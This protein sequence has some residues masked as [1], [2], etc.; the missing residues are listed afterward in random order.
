MQAAQSTVLIF[1]ASVF[2]FFFTSLLPPEAF[3][4]SSTGRVRTEEA[5]TATPQAQTKQGFRLQ[6]TEDEKRWLQGH[7]SV[8]ISGPRAFPPFYFFDKNGDVHGIA[9]DY[10]SLIL[11]YLQLTPDIQANLFWP[12]VL[13]KAKAREIDLISIAAK[14]GD[15]E[16]YLTFTKPF[17]SFPLIIVTREKTPFIGGMRHLQGKRVALVKGNIT[18]DWIVKDEIEVVPLFVKTPLEALQAVASG[19]AEAAVENLAAA[20]YLILHNGL[21]NLK[22]AAPTHYKSYDLHIAIR[23]DWPEL[24]SIIDKILLGITPEQQLEM[25]NKWLKVRY[26]HGINKEDV[27]QW[28]LAVIVVFGTVLLAV[29]LWNRRLRKEIDE[30]TRT[31]HILAESETRF[32]A[33]HN[34]SFGGIAIHDKG[35]IL[36]VNQGLAN[37]SG[38]STEELIGMDGLQLIAEQSRDFVMSKILSGYE[39]PYEAFGL[40]KN[41]DEYPLRLEARNVPYKG[42]TARTVEFRD[43]TE[44]KQAEKALERTRF[45]IEHASDSIFWTTPDGTFID[46]NKAACQALGYSRE[47]FLQINICDLKADYTMEMWHEHFND[48]RQNGSLTFESE[49]R[50]KEGKILPVEIV[51]NYVQ[52]DDEEFNCAFIRDISDRKHAE[53]ERLAFEKQLQHTQKLESLGVM[54]GGIAHDFNNLLTSIMG[55]ADLAL[56]RLSPESPAITNLRNIEKATARAADLAK[57]MLAYSGKGKFVVENIDINNLLKEMMHMLEVSVSKKAVLRFNEFL[58]LPSVEADATQ[59]RQVIM[60]LIINGSEA[61]GDRSGVIAISTGCIECDDRYLED[62]WVDEGISPGLYVFIEITDTGCGMDSETRA[63]L[64]DPFFT[65]KFTGR[66]LG[67]AAVLGIVRGH[68]GAIKIYS[69]VNK[70]TSFKIL[71]PASQ[72]PAQ[73]FN[74]KSNGQDEWQGSGTVLLADD[75][76]SVRAI[77]S[78]MLK[79]LGFNTIT[80]HDGRDAVEKFQDNPHISFVILDLTMPHM[81]GE[82]CFRELR[83]LQPDVQVILSSGFSDEEVTRKFVGRGLVGFIQKPYKLSTLKEIIQ[84]AQ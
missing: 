26:E 73:L 39:K 45:S 66:G 42:I 29:W 41:G 47:E 70:G 48:L 1:T 13:K 84:E 62:A 36:E 20:T 7:N 55:N 17:V 31:E 57:Q 80:A 76:E 63:K 10:V 25:L 3:S 27:V 24:V 56:I 30:R 65:T 49:Q 21:S 75:E 77:G 22:I 32:K 83:K 52:F 6:L 44:Q 78:E 28:T 38:Y 68:K 64:F 5:G 60:N 33:L 58:P 34:A 82:Q 72:K 14:S 37:I 81:D 18:Y 74:G 16:E 79:E 35:L 43:I 4:E 8:R 50:T 15:R 2:L 53:Q 51:A 69:E 12:D 9:A 23:K 40:R 71:L 67:M 46:V 11:K 19:E 61:I 59:L 54:A